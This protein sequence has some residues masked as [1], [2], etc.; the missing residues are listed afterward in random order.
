MPKKSEPLDVKD[1]LQGLETE[2]MVAGGQYRTHRS[3]G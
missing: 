3:R 1:F 2:V